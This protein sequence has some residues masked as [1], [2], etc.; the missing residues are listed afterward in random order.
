MQDKLIRNQILWMHR[1]VD[2]MSMGAVRLDVSSR[3]FLARL[4]S[5]RQLLSGGRCLVFGSVNFGGCLNG[6]VGARHCGD[7]AAS[8]GVPVGGQFW[9]VLPKYCL[10][11]NK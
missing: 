5:S 4:R 2:G 1:W 10:C 8:L 7:V 3:S 9:Y 11:R 6:I